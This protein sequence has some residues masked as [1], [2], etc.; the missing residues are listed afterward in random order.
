MTEL[1]A[2]LKDG[3]ISDIIGALKCMYGKNALSTLDVHTKLTALCMTLGLDFNEFD[4]LIVENSPVLRPVKG[5]AFEVA[6]QRILESVRVPVE[7]VGGDGDVDL[8]INGHHAQLKT[9]NL[10]GCKGD[11]LEYKTHKTHSAKSEKESLSYYHSIESFA[12]FFV[13]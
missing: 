10:G 9:P 6:F 13:G 4:R 12:D 7:D 2:Y 3:R 8:I 5:I 11:V 1:F